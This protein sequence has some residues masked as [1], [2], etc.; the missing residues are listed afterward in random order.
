MSSPQDVTP[1]GVYDLG[2][3]AAE[4]VDAV[5]SDSGRDRQGLATTDAPRVIRGGSFFFSYSV[6]ASLR[7]KRPGNT[8]Q[9]NVGFRCASDVE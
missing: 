3:N 5:Y 1:Q 9:L 4:W 6:H 2:G 7:N 8:A